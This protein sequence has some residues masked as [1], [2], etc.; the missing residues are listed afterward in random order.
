MLDIQRGD[1]IDARREERPH[2]L[3][4]LGARR[5]GRVR[6]RQFVHERHA[7][8]AGEDGVRIHLLDRDALVG[9]RAARDHIEPGDERLGRGAPVRLDEA[10]DDIHALRRE[11]V[12]LF[13][14]RVGLPHPRRR[15]EIEA[16]IPPPVAVIGQMLLLADPGEQIVGVRSARLILHRN[17]RKGDEPQRRR[18]HRGNIGEEIL[19][20]SFPSL[21]PSV[22]LS[23]HRLLLSVAEACRTAASSARLSLRTLTRGWPR[24]PKVRPSV[25]WSTSCCTR[26]RRDLLPRLL[27]VLDDRVH[28]QPRRFRRDVRV[29]P[30]GGCLDEV[31]RHGRRIRDRRTVRPRHSWRPRRAAPCSSAR[32]ST[33]PNR[34]CRSRTARACRCSRSPRGG[35]GSRTADTSGRAPARSATSRPAAHSA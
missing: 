15:A 17:D 7:R 13:E 2:I 6:V 28:L 23:A 12:R 18:A 19:L 29:E 22:P 4:A 31:R 11:P 21:I 35:S 3:V 25:F 20:F 14:H 8:M 32:G 34:R 10:D 27:A 9:D 16:Q 1:D 33:R 26:V 5:A 30:A 24:M